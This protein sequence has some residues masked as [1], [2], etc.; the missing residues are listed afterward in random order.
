MRSD[1]TESN[2]R[3]QLTQV[4]DVAG[5][6]VVVRFLFKLADELSRTQIN[7]LTNTHTRA[8]THINIETDS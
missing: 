5:L 3:N 4:F 8:H 1:S 2:A 6:L 7:A